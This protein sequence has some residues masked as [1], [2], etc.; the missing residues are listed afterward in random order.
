MI[1]LNLYYKINETKK[2]DKK[3]KIENINLISY[4]IFIIYNDDCAF[5]FLN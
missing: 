2:I 4:I 3:K 1:Y 5:F